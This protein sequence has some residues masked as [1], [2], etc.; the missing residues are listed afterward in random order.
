MPDQEGIYIL[1]ELH[2]LCDYFNRPQIPALGYTGNVSRN[3]KERWLESG[4][5]DFIPKHGFD[6][7]HSFIPE[8]LNFV[9]GIGVAELR[10]RSSER[11]RSKRKEILLK[12]MQDYRFDL[13]DAADY[14][15][16]NIGLAKELLISV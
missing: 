2:K 1:R 15:N 8:L 16:F 10:S 5:I 3:D 6:D 14:L 12:V 13:R 9:E 11:T 4:A 7:R